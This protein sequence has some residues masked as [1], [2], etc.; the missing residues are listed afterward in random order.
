MI[1]I[2]LRNKQ[3]LP[4]HHWIVLSIYHIIFIVMILLRFQFYLTNVFIFNLFTLIDYHLIEL[5]IFHFSITSELFSSSEY[6]WVV[7]VV[8]A[9]AGLS[10][11]FGPEKRK[12]RKFQ[13]C[14]ILINIIKICVIKYVSDTQLAQFK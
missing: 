9:A 5:L 8:W 3:N 14:S 7:R 12:L 2:L 6:S 11:Q 13:E 10:G 4:M 1:Y